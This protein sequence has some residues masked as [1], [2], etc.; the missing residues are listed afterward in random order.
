MLIKKQNRRGWIKIVEVFTA[1]LIIAAVVLIAVQ[2]SRGEDESAFERI[3]NDQ[4]LILRTIQ[5]DN[6][7]RA[8]ISSSSLVVPV[9]LTE[10][11]FP[12]TLKNKIESLIPNYI[13]CSAKICAT[14]DLCTLSTAEDKSIYAES[15]IISGTIDTYS[16]R[17]L[18]L[19]CW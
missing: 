12:A 11:G 9:E 3:H 2:Q 1:I 13:N 4:I 18:K 6:S 19:F 7:L 8:E 10:A 5:L 16:P 17:Q 15:V 14:N